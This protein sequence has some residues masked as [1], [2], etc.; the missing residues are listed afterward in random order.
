MFN[1]HVIKELSSYIDN[2]LSERKKAKLEKHLV[3]CE[4]CRLELLQLRTLSE[5]MRTWQVPGLSSDFENKVRNKLVLE[6]LE[7]GEVK[8]KRKP[9]WILVPSTVIAAV[10]MFLVVGK[11]Y[12][13]RG[14]QGT[15]RTAV[16]QIGDEK[17]SSL[18]SRYDPYYLGKKD[19]ESVIAKM[20]AGVATEKARVLNYSDSISAQAISGSAVSMAEGYLWSPGMFTGEFNTEQY[21]RIYDNDFLEAIENPL[22]TFSIDVDTASYSNIRRFLNSNMM[23]P[24]DAVRIE[25][26]LNY[27][28]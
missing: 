5:K 2:Q 15:L 3:R 21:S 8:M 24:Q 11:V 16:D 6:E 4:R 19:E 17:I 1:R 23:P 22:S 9:V 18:K 28:T 20:T 27:F 13:K 14:M 10:L 7:R 12:L 26:M 25:E